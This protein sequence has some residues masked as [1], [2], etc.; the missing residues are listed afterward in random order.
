MI[1]FVLALPS[2]FS[3]RVMSESRLDA[4]A[5]PF[6]QCVLP[7]D[8]PFIQFFEVQIVQAVQS[9][10][11]VQRLRSVPPLN[12]ASFAPLREMPVLISFLARQVLS[13]VERN[14][15][16][17]NLLSFHS[18]VTARTGRFFS[19]RFSRWSRSSRVSP[20]PPTP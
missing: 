9:L 12:L 6:F 18:D 20:L 14:A 17:P 10:R 11:F 13:R 5:K 16:G 7:C 8:S 3:F 2:A 15:K 4:F 19:I 1:F